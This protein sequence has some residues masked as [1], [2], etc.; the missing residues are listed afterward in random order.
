M[1]NHG[2]MLWNAA[3]YNNGAINAK[4][5]IVGQAY[6]D[7]GIALGARES[8]QADG[9]RD[10]TSRHPPLSCPA[11]ALQSQPARQRLPHFRERAARF[12]CSSAFRRSMSR[13]ASRSAGLSERGLGTLNRTDPVFLGAQK[14][15]LHDPLLGFLGSND[16][17]GDYRSSGC[18]ACH[19]VYANDRSP[20][21]SGWWSKYGHQGL[22]FSKDPT[23]PKNERGHPI[24][25]VFTRAIPSAQ[26][27][28]CHMHQ[29]NSLRESVS[30]LHVVGSG[31]GRA[32]TCIRKRAARSDRRRT[33]ARDRAESRGGGGARALG[34]S[35]FP[36]E[37]RGAQSEA[38]AH[39]IR[40]LPRPR[41]DLSRG[42]QAGRK[43][44]P[45]RSR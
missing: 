13:R 42:L 19:V 34:R 35:R 10:E 32:S 28:N 24:Q 39:A 11:A 37:G 3:A 22:S 2:A 17:A 30:R 5:P 15:R 9:R 18:S 41:L 38:E 43:G 45:A 6:G 14:T 21:N 40:R 4:N 23:I 7:D 25:H 29:G 16:R 33:G 26:C 12:R 31:N 1:M 36:R 8:V 44:Q 20:H 27:M